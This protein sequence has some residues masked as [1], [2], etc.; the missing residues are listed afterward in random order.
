MTGNLLLDGL[1]FHDM[2]DIKIGDDKKVMCASSIGSD[3]SIYFS[4]PIESEDC[5]LHAALI[6]YPEIHYHQDFMEYIYDSIQWEV[7]L[8]VIKRDWGYMTTFRLD[9]LQ[10]NNPD[11][12]FFIFDGVTRD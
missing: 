4:I 11:I 3:P 12:F 10:V 2:L 7:F 8:A 5:I 9:W 6:E 1:A